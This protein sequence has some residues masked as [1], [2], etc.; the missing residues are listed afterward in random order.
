V[1][2]RSVDQLPYLTFLEWL[3]V[4]LCFSLKET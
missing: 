1:A 2:V 3:T 4:S